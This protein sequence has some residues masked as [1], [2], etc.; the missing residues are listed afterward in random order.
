MGAG[1]VL[2]VPASTKVATS[3]VVKF[4]ILRF[5]G[6][7]G[8]VGGMEQEVEEGNQMI[9]GPLVRRE[10]EGGKG[11]RTDSAVLY[12]INALL[13]NIVST[14]LWRMNIGITWVFVDR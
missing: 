2:E 7:S 12:I 9:W 6:I 3:G 11:E 4:A 8:S 5:I 14:I 1:S 13:A 10:G